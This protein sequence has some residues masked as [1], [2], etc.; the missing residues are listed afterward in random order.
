M[1]RNGYQVFDSDMHVYDAQN[2]YEKYM[3]PKWGERIPVG[4]A[5]TKHGRIEFSLGNGEAL[6]P[7]NQTAGARRGQGGGPLRLRAGARL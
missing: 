5:R 6:R 3:K 2:L 1:A 4:K 7:R